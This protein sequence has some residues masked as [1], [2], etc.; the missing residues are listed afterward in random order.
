MLSHKSARDGNTALHGKFLCQMK[1]FGA[2]QP[3]DWPCQFYYKQN[4]Y[5]SF[6]KFIS[7]QLGLKDSPHG[8]CPLS[9]ADHSSYPCPSTEQAHCYILNDTTPKNQMS[10]PSMLSTVLMLGGASPYF[11]RWSI[12]FIQ[13][14]IPFFKTIYETI[15]PRSRLADKPKPC[16]VSLI[17]EIVYGGR[18]WYDKLLWEYS[19]FKDVE[20]GT[21]FSLWAITFLWSTHSTAWLVTK[22]FFWVLQIWIMFTCLQHQHY[23][24]AALVW[25]TWEKNGLLHYEMPTTFTQRLSGDIKEFLL[26]SNKTNTVLA[27]TAHFCLCLSCS[28]SS[29]FTNFGTNQI[30]LDYYMLLNFLS[31]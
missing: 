25:I 5:K 26:C 7:Y 31:Y 19:R 12:T 22:Y 16:W 20:Y 17:L 28:S 29:I 18:H 14:F 24:K 27:L 10:Q 21:L 11:P 1:T 13:L 30:S 3:E 23:N 6:N 15:F 4:I 8:H 9:T 2:F